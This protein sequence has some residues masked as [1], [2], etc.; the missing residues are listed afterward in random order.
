MKVYKSDEIRNVVLLGHGGCG[1]SSLLEAMA[2]ASG[3]INRMGKTEDH[4]TISDFDK[5]EQKRGFSISMTTY[6]IEWEKSKINVM[7]T[8]GFFGFVGEVEEAASAADAAIIIVSGKSGIEVGT[9]KA[10]EI[11]DKFDLPRMFFV[12]DM[13]VDNVSYHD[14]VDALVEKFGKKVAPLYMPLREDGKLT[15]YVNIVLNKGRKFTDNIKWENHTIYDQLLNEGLQ[16]SLQEYY[17]GQVDKD[18]ALD[19]FYKYVNET[20]PAIETP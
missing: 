13:D 8:P 12:T 14:V 1:K 19:N 10:W 20:Y 17:K 4:N 5:E 18:T 9:E 7:D 15:G 2:F 11:C 3:A 6:P 16:N